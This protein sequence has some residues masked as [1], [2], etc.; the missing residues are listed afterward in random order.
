MEYREVA[1]DNGRL[2][3]SEVVQERGMAV[4]VESKAIEGYR[5]DRVDKIGGTLIASDQR[6]RSNCGG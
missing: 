2:T 1:Y 5:S 3:Y 6:C 4:Y